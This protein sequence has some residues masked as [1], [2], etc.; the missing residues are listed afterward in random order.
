MGILLQQWFLCLQLFGCFHDFGLYDICLDFG[1]GLHL[2]LRL[3]LQRG[4]RRDRY[5][6]L[7]FNGEVEFLDRAILHFEVLET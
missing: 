5:V 4:V 2:S 6:L 3:C 7:V 1:H